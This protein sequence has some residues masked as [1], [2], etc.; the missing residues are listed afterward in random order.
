MHLYGPPVKMAD[1]S[2]DRTQLR[3]YPCM[4]FTCSG[5]IVKLM[6]VAPVQRDSTASVRWPEFGLW[7]KCNRSHSED[8]YWMEVQRLSASQQP[9]LVYMNESQTVGVYEIEFTSNNTFEHGNILGIVR[10]MATSNSS[11]MN[12]LYQNGGGYCNALAFRHTQWYIWQLHRF[13][14]LISV[15]R[16]PIIPYITI[17]T[18]QI[19]MKIWHII[20]RWL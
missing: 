3:L 2:N 17:E 19:C 10:P 20:C 6:F 8:C 14:P 15:N 1:L 4:N 5:R 16:Q 7:R 9:C 13:I 12:V 11:A 18:G